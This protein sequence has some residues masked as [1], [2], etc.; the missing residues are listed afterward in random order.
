MNGPTCR[1]KARMDG[2]AVFITGGN[3]GLGYETTKELLRRGARVGMLVQEEK[4]GKNAIQKLNTELRCHW[5]R[6]AC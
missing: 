5:D 3:T 6:I 1:S 2:K 4:M